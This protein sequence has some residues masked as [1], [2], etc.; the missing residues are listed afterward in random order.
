ML[1]KRGRRTEYFGGKSEC[2]PLSRP[3]NIGSDSVDKHKPNIKRGTDSPNSFKE[4][5][6]HVT[7][8]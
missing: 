7:S 4:D 2:N 3:R 6:S 5:L 1:A 8:H